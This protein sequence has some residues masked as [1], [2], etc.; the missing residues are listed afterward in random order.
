MVET[1]AKEFGKVNVLVNN[2]AIL[3]EE[4]PIA[5]CKEEDF[6]ILMTVNFKSVWLCMKYAIPEMLKARGG[7]I[8]NN[9]SV[10]AFLGQ[11]GMGAYSAAKAAIHSL[12]KVVA[13]EYAD[14]NI[15]V[16]YVMPGHIG[17]PLFYRHQTPEAL[18]KLK[19][20]TFMHRV[21]EPEEVARAMLFLASDESSWTTGSA[22]TTDGGVS[23]R[24]P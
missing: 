21:G 22:L 14:K 20:T 16:N 8:V 5:D 6:D 24:H 23:T 9:G 18:A 12:S 19:E 17:T 11:P 13:M 3:R 15:R 2:A 4:G 1:T 7:S 10:A